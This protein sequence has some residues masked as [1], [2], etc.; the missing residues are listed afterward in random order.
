MKVSRKFNV[1]Q[2][3]PHAKD[4][5]RAFQLIDQDLGSLFQ[6]VNQIDFRSGGS[7]NKIA[8]ISDGA[9]PDNI[10]GRFLVYTSNSVA[11]TDDTLNHKLGRAPVG[12]IQIEAPVV[13]GDTENSGRVYFSDT[14]APTAMTV[15]L[16]CTTA[17]KRCVV[18]LL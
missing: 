12:L 14:A 2:F 15:I 6:A 16:K 9:V 10:D 13:A 18:L 7:G 17:S 1:D 8:T 4:S 11:N 3:D 5:S